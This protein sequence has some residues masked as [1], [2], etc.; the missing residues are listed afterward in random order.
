MSRCRRRAA[1]RLAWD[2]WLLGLE[3]AAVVGQRGLRIA[4][5]GRAGKTESQRMVREKVDAAVAWQ[6]LAA[7]GGLGRTAPGAA[8]KTLRH[9]RRKVRAN[10]R[11]LAKS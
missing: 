6:I 10:R 3:A 4:A 11:R 9:Y 8:A 1:A 7:T 2:S 5:G